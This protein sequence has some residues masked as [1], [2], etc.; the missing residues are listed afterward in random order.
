MS[1]KKF[2]CQAITH[3]DNKGISISD[4]EHHFCLAIEDATNKLNYLKESIATGKFPFAL[5]LVN[6]CPKLMVGETIKYY[7][8]QHDAEKLLH[9]LDKALH[10]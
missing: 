2:H 7:L 1:K 8:H 5:E 6:S 4:D 9:S 10:H 3:M